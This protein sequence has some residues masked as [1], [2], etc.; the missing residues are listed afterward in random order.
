MASATANEL[1][2]ESF[3]PVVGRALTLA[4]AVHF[5]LLAFGPRIGVAE[6]RRDVGEM[7]VLETPR[8]FEI[9]PPPDELSR[10]AVPVLSTDLSVDPDQTIA[11]SVFAD[12]PP[13]SLPEPPRGTM[14]VG[15]EKFTPFEIR[16]RFSNPDR[17]LR[18]LERQYP[19]MLRDAGV[20]GTVVLWV[21]IDEQGSVLETQVFESSAYPELDAAAERVMREVARFTPALNRD[22]R[23]AVWVQ[24]PVSFNVR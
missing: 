14:N 12:N 9:P 19:P 3:N 2:K 8:E 4:A 21:H 16:P 15:T 18:A 20:G 23:V 11:P 5:A 1:L 17:Y 22:R 24:I 7:R 10:P 6:M 13:T